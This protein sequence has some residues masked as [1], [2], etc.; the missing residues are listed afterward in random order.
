MVE[1]WRMERRADT[2]YERLRK[3]PSS[4]KRHTATNAKT[5]NTRT[6]GTT[7]SIELPAR[8]NRL[9]AVHRVSLEIAQIGRR[10]RNSDGTL[11]TTEFY[12]SGVVF[13]TV[14]GICALPPSSAIEH[15]NG[16][17]PF[18]AEHFLLTGLAET[19]RSRT[20]HSARKEQ[21][22]LPLSRRAVG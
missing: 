4:N 21:N 6:R 20:N 19:C 9:R 17:K 15:S 12:R 14:A 3:S 13:R 16:T 2:R 8:Q 7:N 1:S 22:H 5:A 11:R 10:I 18:G